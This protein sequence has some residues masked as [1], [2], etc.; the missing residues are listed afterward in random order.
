MKDTIKL[1]EKILDYVD[2]ATILKEDGIV[3]TDMSEEQIHCPFHGP[4][5]KK[6][7]RFYKSTD[8]V[9]CWT[10]K[11]SWDLFSYLIQ[12]EGVSFR[13]ILDQL[14]KKY[15]IDISEVPDAVEGAKQKRLESKK[16]KYDTKKFYLE[17]LHNIVKSIKDE[18]PQEKYVRLVFAFMLLKYS[19]ED[20][21]FEESIIKIRD[22][23]LRL[24]KEVVNG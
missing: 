24:K 16:V 3:L 7:S 21:K 5:N 12:K 23:V 4:D 1:K 10:C 18:I 8:S 11:Q 6:S 2:L 13:E 19:T 15:K 20:E 17:K 14:V 9:Y 22:A